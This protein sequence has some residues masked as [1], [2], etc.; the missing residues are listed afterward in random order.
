MNISIIVYDVLGRR[1]KTLFNGLQKKG[2][3]HITW[4]GQDQSGSKV[5][6]GIYFYEMR[7][8]GFIQTRKM[9]LIK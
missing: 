9:L 8:E 6:S 1:V 3:H 7:G 4:F 5:S 2:N